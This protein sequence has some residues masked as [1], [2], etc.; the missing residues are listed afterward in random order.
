MKST[1]LSNVIPG[2]VIAV[3]GN[4]DAKQPLV[5]FQSETPCVYFDY[6]VIRHFKKR[7]RRTHRDGDSTSSL[8]KR[9]ET[10]AHDSQWIPFYINDDSGRINVYPDGAWFEGVSVME[11]VEP[12]TEK[13]KNGL[14]DQKMNLSKG[15]GTTTEYRIRENA[16]KLDQPA[17]VVGPVNEHGQIKPNARHGVIVSHRPESELRTE[18]TG[19]SRKRLFGCFGA[20]ALS[21]LALVAGT[22]ATA[23]SL[24]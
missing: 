10:V 17:F 22:V 24:I 9:T 13:N 19:H 4:P 18:W 1:E 21:I 16:V 8:V 23:M 6:E 14:R 15:G 2:Q 11:R 12:V 3:S 20:F 5:S 7:V